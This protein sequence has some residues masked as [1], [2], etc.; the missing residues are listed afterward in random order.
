MVSLIDVLDGT[1]KPDRLRGKIAF[2]GAIEPMLGDSKLVPVDKSN[3]YPGVLIHANEL[4]TMLTS[5][6]W[7]RSATPRPCSGSCS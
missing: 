1:V 7:R 2:V 4:N 6:S 3:T 5:S